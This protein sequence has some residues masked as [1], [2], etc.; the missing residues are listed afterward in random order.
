[1]AAQ[2]QRRNP[3]PQQQSS[4]PE[5]IQRTIPVVNTNL[6]NLVPRSELRGG[7]ET[8]EM[9]TGTDLQRGAG[10]R[11]RQHIILALNVLYVKVVWLQEQSPAH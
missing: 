6:S 8:V 4:G 2:C 9:G 1:M 5:R 3:S 11:V 7:E 10:Q